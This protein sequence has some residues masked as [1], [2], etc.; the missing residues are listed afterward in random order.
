MNSQ[1]LNLFSL[2]N[3]HLIS[4]SKILEEQRKAILN[5]EIDAIEG[6]ITKINLVVRKLVNIEKEKKRIIKDDTSLQNEDIQKIIREIRNNAKIVQFQNETN[7]T[8][9]KQKSIYN[10]NL[11]KAIDPNYKFRKYDSKGRIEY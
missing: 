6:S 5:S 2:E 1:V 8:L 4:F 10:N 11:L 3:E 9:I 7:A